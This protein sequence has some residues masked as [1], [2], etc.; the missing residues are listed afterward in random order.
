MWSIRILDRLLAGTVEEFSLCSRFLDSLKLP[1]DEHLYLAE[2][3]LETGALEG[4]S[5]SAQIPNISGFV[6]LVGLLDIWS[7]ILLEVV[8]SANPH[9]IL[10]DN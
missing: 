1:C 2:M 5:G 3:P 7:E 4:F 10:P 8:G 6:G 9:T